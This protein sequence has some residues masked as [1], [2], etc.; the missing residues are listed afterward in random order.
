MKRRRRPS[1]PYVPLSGCHR[2]AVPV[3]SRVSC[4]GETDDDHH[5]SW[6]GFCYDWHCECGFCPCVGPIHESHCGCPVS[7]ASLE[8]GFVIESI[9]TKM[10]TPTGY[11]DGSGFSM[12][13]GS[14]CGSDSDHDSGFAMASSDGAWA[15]VSRGLTTQNGCGH[16]ETGAAWWYLGELRACGNGIVRVVGVVGGW[17]TE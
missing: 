2:A 15:R 7:A 17:V 8:C 1:G 6:Q 16:A 12:C 3:L 14:R 10:W 13:C 5:T 11:S 9:E 4:G